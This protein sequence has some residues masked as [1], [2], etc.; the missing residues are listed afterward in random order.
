M[1]KNKFLLIM[2]ILFIIIAIAGIVLIIILTGSNNEAI[3]GVEKKG[4]LAKIT[5]SNSSKQL[6]QAEEVILPIKI[7]YSDLSVEQTI[8][9]VTKISDVV[10]EQKISAKNN[11]F[12][13]VEVHRKKIDSTQI[14]VIYNIKVKN[15]GNDS[16]KVDKLIATI[17]ENMELSNE[18]SLV[19]QK[20]DE[21]NIEC[22]DV[23]DIK[24]GSEK[25]VE[26]VLTGKASDII[27][28]N[29]S[30]V[31]LI[32][33]EEADQR[34][35]EKEN[36]KEITESNAKQELGKT[37][38]YSSAGVIISIETSLKD[39]TFIIILIIICLSIGV[40]GIRTYMKNNKE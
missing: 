20:T 14:K 4:V 8:E 7:S 34:I 2:S 21:S 32:S 5:P 31:I 24:A 40:I 25:N 13:K 11:S 22:I 29:T 9:K 19:W 10:Q 27:G 12:A 36:K 6:T 23:G 3:R 16:G 1:K 28:E 26:L 37:N 39:Y 17:P 18:S 15:E 33:S 38:N 35:I 30:D